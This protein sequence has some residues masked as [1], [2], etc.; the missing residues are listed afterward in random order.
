MLQKNFQ[1]NL[2]MKKSNVKKGP[3]VV[4]SF[5]T[6]G[7]FDGMHLCYSSSFIVLKHKFEI[8]K[9][10]LETRAPHLKK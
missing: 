3:F 2:L 1:K 6:I 8:D 4:E 7:S 10:F 5:V 9:Y